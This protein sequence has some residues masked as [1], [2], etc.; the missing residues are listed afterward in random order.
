[1]KAV[2]NP[3]KLAEGVRRRWS[4]K[5]LLDSFFNSISFHIHYVSLERHVLP[6][7]PWDM[8]TPPPQPMGVCR[9]DPIKIKFVFF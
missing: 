6:F 4:L 1:M 9:K 3:Q 2:L 5:W 7:N 8:S